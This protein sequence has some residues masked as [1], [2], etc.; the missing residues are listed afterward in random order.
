MPA[1]SWE[2]GLVGS[3]LDRRH[4]DDDLK[5]GV[6]EVCAKSVRNLV[7]DGL[8][9]PWLG[10]ESVSDLFPLESLDL[11]GCPLSFLVLGIGSGGRCLLPLLLVPIL[12]REA[13]PFQ[14]VRVIAN[15]ALFRLVGSQ[16][17]GVEILPAVF[18]VAAINPGSA[19]SFP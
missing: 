5:T 10:K 9:G 12:V 11:A 14:R 19:N 15:R 2:N 13:V 17:I 16:N 1:T 7:D 8:E 3:E 4:L 6:L 18:V